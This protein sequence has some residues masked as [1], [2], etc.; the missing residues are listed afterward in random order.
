M[1]F[2]HSQSFEVIDIC[3]NRKP[4]YDLLRV[5]ELWPT[6][7]LNFCPLSRYS[8]V[9]S[10][11]LHSSSTRSNMILTGNTQVR[12]STSYEERPRG[13]ADFSLETG[14][15]SLIF[16]SPALSWNHLLS[17]LIRCPDPAYS[18]GLYN[19]LRKEMTNFCLATMLLQLQWVTTSSPVNV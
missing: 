11:P 15:S 18:S 16:R 10:K 13:P 9:K 3:T 17:S 19:P 4:M 5:G 6:G 14:P 2:D 12:P 8:A 1:H 7:E